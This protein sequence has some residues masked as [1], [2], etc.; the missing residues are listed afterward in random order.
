VRLRQAVV[1]LESPCDGVARLARRLER[2]DEA[3]EAVERV[4]IGETGERQCIARILCERLLEEH[5]RLCHGLRCPTE[6]LVA[7]F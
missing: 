6:E 3:V 5:L 4:M 7:T 1:D 2:R